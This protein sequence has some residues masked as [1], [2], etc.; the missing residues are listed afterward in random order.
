MADGCQTEPTPGSE[1]VN[2][3][4]RRGKSRGGEGFSQTGEKYE[5]RR[6]GKPKR[7][8][9][10]VVAV[11]LAGRRASLSALCIGVLAFLVIA[12]GAQA[13]NL[14]QWT[15]AD[16][17]DSIKRGVAYIDLHQNLNGSFGSPLVV[18][19]AETGM[20]LVAYSVLAH[21]DF[22]NL[23]QYNAAYPAH[24]KKAIDYL[25]INQ[26]ALGWWTEPGGCCQTYDT[27]IALGGLGWLRN[28]SGVNP[29]L[30]AAID[31]G[32]NFLVGEFKGPNLPLPQ[33]C[34]SADSSPTAYFCGGWNYDNSIDLRSDESNTGFAMFGLQFSGGVPQGPAPGGISVDD[35]NW[36]RHIQELLGPPGIGNPFATRNDGGG[37]YQP[38]GLFGDHA[39]NANDTGT[40]LFSFAYDNLPGGISAPQVAAGLLFAQ[41]ILDVYELERNLTVPIYNMIYHTGQNRSV[42][43]IGGVGCE[44]FFSGGEG[45]FHYSMF[46]LSKGIGAYN[47]TVSLTDPTNWYAKV[48]DLL[49]SQQ[50]ADG[51]WPADGRDDVDD[52]L[53]T[54]FSVPG[55][56]CLGCTG[57]IEICKASDPNHPV[58]GSFTFTATAPDFNSGP[59]VVPVGQCSGSIKASSGG[60]TVTE[61][62]KLGVAVSNVTAIA[63]DE[64]GFLHNELSSWTQPDLHA[65][66]NVMAGDQDEETLTTFTNYAAPPGLLKLCK[67]AGDQFTLGQIFT[68]TVTSGTQRNV[69]MIQAGPPGQG[70][71]CVLAGNFPVN[72]QVTIA[73]TPKFPF[74]PSRITVNE[75]Q[76]MACQPPSIYCTVASVIP[77]ITE[78]T[79][80][81][82]LR[83]GN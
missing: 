67:V 41:D 37:G 51:H 10:T 44:W 69:Y 5:N 74:R 4:C 8:S 62:P 1:A 50:A 15:Q 29:L 30:P 23:A 83:F 40:M 64:L 42:C 24:V 61:T 28:V 72:T 19:V 59:I 34:S 18:P 16:V 73:E 9:V 53:A 45:G 66:V 27:G 38:L 11:A 56:G 52:L 80:T 36:Q 3:K 63:Y 81:N 31:K 68:F 26:N 25:V 2:R 46:S 58:T 60:V 82:V 71:Y 57:Y 48:V 13:K 65:I 21:G 43:Q 20:A 79:F 70:G 33:T 12:P 47:S 78:V 49:L 17:D 39:S 6:Q 14:G 75:G 35:I 55:P 54:E 22:N 32:R 76:L 7:K 77:G